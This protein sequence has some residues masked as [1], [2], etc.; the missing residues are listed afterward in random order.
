ML[1]ALRSKTCSTLTATA[2]YLCVTLPVHSARFNSTFFHL[3]L[4]PK[5]ILNLFEATKIAT[6]QIKVLYMVNFAFRGML[7]D[8]SRCFMP[9]KALKA[10][11]IFSSTLMLLSCWASL[12]RVLEFFHHIKAIV[13]K[14]RA[15]K[16]SCL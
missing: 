5:E 8:R 15:D 9:L 7:F 12:T 6:G 4:C 11:V 3:L 2:Q 10:N 14:M 13:S 16:I 1:I